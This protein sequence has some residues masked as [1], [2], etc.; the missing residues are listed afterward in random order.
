MESV[1]PITSLVTMD[2]LNKTKLATNMKEAVVTGRGKI[3]D[4][5]TVIAVMDSNFMMGSKD[6]WLEK[7]LQEL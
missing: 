7:K 2:K 3:A 6:R 1:N 4:Y 5:H